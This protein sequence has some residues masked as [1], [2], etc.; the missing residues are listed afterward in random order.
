AAPSPLSPA[1]SVGG[2]G[3]PATS[4]DFGRIFPNLPPFADATPRVRAALVEVGMPG[5]IL[6]ARD[7]LT[8]GPKALIVDPAVTGNSTSFNRDGPNP[9]S[10]PITCG[11]RFVGQFGRHDIT[12]DQAA[13][14]GVPQTPLTS[15]NTRS[16]ALDLDSVFGGG[17]GLRP[18][19]YVQNP[20]GSVG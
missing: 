4:V 8:A 1:R 9:G 7:D 11:S 17:P 3:V 18:D 2:P 10:P 14:L 15:P 5:G 12:L 16:P 19:L 13:Q 6:D 20:D